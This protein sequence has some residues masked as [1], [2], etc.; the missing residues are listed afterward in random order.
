MSDPILVLQ[1]DE[2][3]APGWLADVLDEA[4]VEQTLVELFAGEPLPDTHR[5]WA[6]VVS[7]GG[8][9]AAWEEDEHPFLAREKRL[10]R[11]AVSDDVPVLGICLGSQVL[12][13]A[14]G[15]R[16]F[17]GP[18]MEAGLVPVRRTAA[19]RA[20]PVVSQLA[21]PVMSFHSDT[22]DLPPAAR[23]LAVSDNYAQA[24]RL[25]SG[26]G[27]QFH[28]E[29]SP[30]LLE[31]WVEVARPILEAS[32]HDTDALMDEAR[33]EQENAHRTGQRLFSAWLSEVRRARST[34]AAPTR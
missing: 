20:D 5:N 9:M 21:G 34:P 32:G 25:G 19:G 22:W 12:A 29:A 14:L 16:A 6:A 13:E 33:R 23:L 17:R 18:Q 15:G 3:T 8:R 10:L 24:F 26:L 30:A 27:L 1:H 31:R 28:P 4:G 2:I 11:A 7:L